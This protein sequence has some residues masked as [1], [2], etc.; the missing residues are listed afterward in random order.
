MLKQAKV[1]PCQEIWQRMDSG[2]IDNAMTLIALQWLRLNHETLRREW[3]R[4]L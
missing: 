4:P 3:A 2:S 1:Y